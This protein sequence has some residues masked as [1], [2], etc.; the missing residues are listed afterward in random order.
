MKNV[1]LFL[2]FLIYV[3]GIFFVENPIILCFIFILN[4]LAMIIYRI[5][6]IDALESIIKILPFIALTV[7]IN[8]ILSSYSYAILIGIKLILVCNITYIY[9]K[10]ITV[11]ELAQ[12]IK[13]ICTPLKLF[14]INPDEI[15]LLVC[16]SLSMIPILKEECSQLKNACAA[17]GIDVNIKNT[18]IILSKLMV[19]I[20]K[21]VNE[22]EESIIEKGYS[23]DI[24]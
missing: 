12:V 23:E 9:S 10:T 18:K 21:K 7:I 4:I 1:V 22:I 3:T 16:I 5:K 11:R 6:L 8:W 15:E 14:H 13:K 17:K 24:I 2:V 20:M 19:S